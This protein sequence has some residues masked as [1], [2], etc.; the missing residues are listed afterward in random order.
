MGGFF[1]WS[2][3]SGAAW[4][5]SP[6]WLMLPLDKMYNELKRTRDRDKRFEIYKRANEYIADYAFWVFTVA[7]L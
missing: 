2:F 3:H 1:E 7:P 6:D 5:T 4:Q